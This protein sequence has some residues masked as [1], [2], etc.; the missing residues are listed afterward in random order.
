MY[1]GFESLRLRAIQSIGRCR[2]QV[3]H[4]CLTGYPSSACAC[5]DRPSD[6]NQPLVAPANALFS[7]AEGKDRTRVRAN[8]CQ[9]FV[10]GGRGKRHGAAVANPGLTV[11]GVAK[12]RRPGTVYALSDRKA[13][14]VC[15]VLR[16]LKHL[17]ARWGG[18]EAG[19]RVPKAFFCLRKLFPA[20]RSPLSGVQFAD[21]PD[22]KKADFPAGGTFSGTPDRPFASGHSYLREGDSR[23]GRE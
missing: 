6:T 19:K 5:K 9:R 15:M 22:G 17:L 3:R 1:R 18:G 23:S 2:T 7:E 4:L 11:A 8:P 10:L 16:H 14:Q 20:S 12:W 21:P 13:L